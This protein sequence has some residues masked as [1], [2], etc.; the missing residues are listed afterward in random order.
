MSVMRWYLLGGLLFLVLVAAIVFSLIGADPAVS[1]PPPEPAAALAPR[2]AA[3][4]QALERT[5]PAPPPAPARANAVI[6]PPP[7]PTTAPGAERVAEPMDP[8]YL[9][10]IG[11]DPAKVEE[12]ADAG[13][14]FKVDKDGIRAA[15]K[16]K[17]PEIKE[18]YDS[19]LRTNPDL[20][21]KLKLTFTISEMPGKSRALVSDIDVLDGGIGHVAMEGCVKNVFSSMRFEVPEHGEMKVTYPLNFSSG[22]DGG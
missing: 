3:T 11:V 5:V 16:E 4:A 22:R 20:G 14:L 13:P 10:A 21:G 9:A 18:C 7:P 6:P 8:D 15:V 19:W 12:P 17:V 2:P 1:P